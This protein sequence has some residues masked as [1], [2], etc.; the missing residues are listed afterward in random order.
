MTALGTSADR[1]DGWAKV[2]GTARY[3]AD[4][5]G[6]DLLHAVLVG[7]TVPS[8]RLTA[9]DVTA[10]ERAP[11]VRLVLTSAN[12]GPL[13]ALPDGS[14]WSGWP[15]ESRPPLADDV[16]NYHGQ[17]IAMVVADTVENAQRGAALVVATYDRAPFA[18]DLADTTVA[19]RPVQ[20]MG[21]ELQVARGDVDSA[22]TSAPVRVDQTYRTANNHPTAME[23]H[24]SVASWS[25]GC[26][27]VHNSTQWVAGNQVVLAAAFGLPQERVRVVSPFVGGMFGSK[28]ATGAGTILAAVAAR[29][30]GA[31]VKVVLSRAQVL[32]TV[33]HRSE[34]VQR[35]ELGAEPDGTLLAVRHHTV[36]HAS[37]DEGANPAE[38]HEPTSSVTRV[39]YASPTY[40]AT[41]EARR[42]NVIP[43]GWMR[44]PGEATGMWALES[45]MDELADRVGVDPLELRRRNHA[46]RDPHHD[47]PWSSKHL[48]E[49]Y[50]RGAERFGW[51]GRPPGV[52]AMRDGGDVLGWGM[53]TASYPCWRFGATVRVRVGLVD[54]RPRA[55]VST[56]GS[57]VGNGAY[58]VLTLTA[59][60]SLGIDPAQVTVELGDTSLPRSSQT[61]G[62]GLTA[63]TAPAVVEA[64]AAILARLGGRID[65]L[66]AGAELVEEAATEPVYLR[67]E[68]LAYQSFGAHFVEVRVAP[69][70]G[71]VRV[72]RVV[73]VFDIGRVLSAK[74]TRSQLAGA[75]VFGIGQALHEQL[76]YDPTNGRPA[77]AD[78]AGY[79]VPVNADIPKIDVSWLDIPDLRF[80]PL[81]CRGAGEIGITG[82]ASAVASAV[83]H[84]TGVRVRSLPITPNFML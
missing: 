56:A 14:D 6:A 3:A 15:A 66:T 25:D 28:V 46:D 80:N 83:H 43:P 57:E 13:G 53:A 9:L 68:D 49:C 78:L 18:T 82:L 65:A 41:H 11:G 10:A 71:R 58:T 54:G 81:G 69:D 1:V 79:L 26:L 19:D 34:T 42:M 37:V 64:C 39:L 40:A 36:A 74:T 8:G 61:G 7:S 16:V 29:H 32:T 77:N 21:E 35:V 5:T 2:T 67:D 59:A 76:D 55:V 72:S 52:G 62:S 63:S 60:D 4:L 47:L 73:S 70:L 51:A 12:R 75:I 24:A 44:A 20:V 30:L 45:A 33:G 27:T 31:A 22:L 84:A 23:P 48:L 38:F 17:Y 50:D